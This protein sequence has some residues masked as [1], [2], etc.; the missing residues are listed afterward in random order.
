MNRKK[1]LKELYKNTK[2][3]MGAFIIKSETRNKCLVEGTGDLK[4]SMNSARFKLNFGNHPNRELQKDWK[5]DGESGFTMEILEKLK[6][7]K[8]E[9]KDDYSEE[10]SILKM[11]WEERLQKKGWQFY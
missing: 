5:E 4:G 6:Y 7:D 8:D 3:D 10:L 1:E 9:T 2:P 11:I